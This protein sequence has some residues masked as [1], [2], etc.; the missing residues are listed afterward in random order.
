MAAV[1]DKGKANAEAK[2]DAL[3]T[4]H[5]LYTDLA[6]TPEARAVAYRSLFEGA[7]ASVRSSNANGVALD[8]T[9]D[10]LDRLTHVTDPAT[11]ALL[12][13]SR[14][15][16]KY[17]SRAIVAGSAMSTLPTTLPSGPV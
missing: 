10:A 17:N 4:P 6:A 13:R 5:Q 1:P 3:I 9:Y 15:I 8:Y 11:G 14:R 12:A 7:V 16:A 2:A